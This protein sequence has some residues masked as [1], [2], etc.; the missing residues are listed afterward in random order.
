MPNNEVSQPKMMPIHKIEP[1]VQAAARGGATT[2]TAPRA[3]RALMPAQPWQG[4][5]RLIAL[6]YTV[7]PSLKFQ[8]REPAIAKWADAARR[9]RRG[10][11]AVVLA[12]AGAAGALLWSSAP[13]DPS[14][15]WMLYA[16]LGVL[17]TA[18]V[19]AGTATAL[20]GALVLLRGD[21]HALK[22]T[23]SH[24]PIDVQAR[25]AIIMPICN[26]DIATVFSG[27]RATAESL[28][29]TGALKLFDFY[30]L[31]DTTDPPCV[32]PS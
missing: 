13:A 31:S 12:F 15:A 7:M 20:M 18:W 22:L 24:A 4:F 26:E 1:P 23:D 29:A 17:L 21:H 5:L 25:T 6:L 3:T 28:A 9:R 27:L 11:L 30:L 16:G 19:G 8:W 2:P 32:R 14:I 10:L